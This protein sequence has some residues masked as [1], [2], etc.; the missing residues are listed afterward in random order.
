MIRKITVTSGGHKMNFNDMQALSF[1][2]KNLHDRIEIYSKNNEYV[3]ADVY[4]SWVK[5]Y[6]YLLDNSNFPYQLVC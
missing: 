5:E 1:E 2:I 4:K 6:N 3:Y